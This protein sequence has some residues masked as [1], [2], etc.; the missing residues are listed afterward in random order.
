MRLRR[1]IVALQQLRE[2]SQC[3]NGYG[4]VFG[5]TV[6]GPERGVEDDLE[7]VFRSC[8]TLIMRFPVKRKPETYP[9]W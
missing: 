6:E 9:E 7:C 8:C 2:E 5:E 1:G 3:R 4:F